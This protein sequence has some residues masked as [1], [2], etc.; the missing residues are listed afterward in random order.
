MSIPTTAPMSIPTT[1][2]MSIPT[3][4]PMSIPT[5]APSLPSSDAPTST[6]AKLLLLVS[7]LVKGGKLTQKQRDALKD[8]IIKGD[9]NL[10]CALEVFEIEKD[11]DELADTFRR[12]ADA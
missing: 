7:M 11:F 1:A 5:T 6:Y 8:R 9:A 4:A 10:T 2:P 12:I 3:A